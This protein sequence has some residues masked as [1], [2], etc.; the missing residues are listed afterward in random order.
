MEKVNTLKIIN[1]FEN[2]NA[3]ILELY[4]KKKC[5]SSLKNDKFK[6]HLERGLLNKMSKFWLFFPNHFLYNFFE[7]VYNL[8]F[9]NFSLGNVSSRAEWA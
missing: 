1:R 3:R 2:F 4:E 8:F 6:Y 9:L 5:K 7:I